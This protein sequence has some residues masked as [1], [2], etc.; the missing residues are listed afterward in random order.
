MRDK[1]PDYE[2]LRKL[3]DT[4]QYHDI[5]FGACRLAL[6]LQEL[7]SGIQSDRKLNNTKF[8]SNLL[9]FLLLNKSD[10]LT[11]IMND[12]SI[13]FRLAPTR[14]KNGKVTGW[15]PYM[16]LNDDGTTPEYSGTELISE[17]EYKWRDTSR[18]LLSALNEACATISVLTGREQ[19]D[20]FNQLLKGQPLI[21]PKEESAE[22]ATLITESKVGS[23]R[24]S[25]SDVPRNIGQLPS[26]IMDFFSGSAATAHA[27]MQ[28]NAEDGGNRRFILVQSPEPCKEGSEALKAGYSTIAEIGKERIRRAAKKIA[29]D[30]P[31]AE[32]DGGF[33]VYK[34]EDRESVSSTEKHPE[35][36]STGLLGRNDI[37]AAILSYY[38]LPADTAVREIEILG[39]RFWV[40]GDNRIIFSDDNGVTVEQAKAI[41]G[42]KPAHIVVTNASDEVTA[43]VK[44]YLETHDRIKL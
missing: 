35:C 10:M 1:V 36:P 43:E 44:K 22:N 25:K 20:V 42:M 9:G 4:Q 26:I 18:V 24:I 37:R 3:Y 19:G 41:C 31:R 27:V 6:A 5:W 39:G 23:V 33:Q 40:V 7:I 32:F 30:N 29:S 13:A 15:K 21:T 8:V 16:L 38:S 17:N 28:L 11:Y 34:V 2:E 12:S 14:N